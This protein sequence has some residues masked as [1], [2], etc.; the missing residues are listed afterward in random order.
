[1]RRNPPGDV[2]RAPLL[3]DVRDSDQRR[4]GASRVGTGVGGVALQHLAQAR[5]AEVPHA[6]LVQRHR[7]GASSARAGSRVAWRASSATVSSRRRKGSSTT[8]NTRD[9]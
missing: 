7:Q 6:H 9:A 8:S 2:V 1:M 3:L 5:V 4:R